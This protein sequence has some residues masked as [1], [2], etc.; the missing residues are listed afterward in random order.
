MDLCLLGALIH[1]GSLDAVSAAEV[2]L[3]HLGYELSGEAGSA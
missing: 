2:L 3:S 1:A